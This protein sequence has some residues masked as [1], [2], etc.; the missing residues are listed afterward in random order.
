M[1]QKV[2]PEEGGE[3]LGQGLR[4]VRITWSISLGA[5]GKGLDFSRCLWF[6]SFFF[7]CCES[8]ECGDHCLW[9]CQQTSQLSQVSVGGKL[10]LRSDSSWPLLWV[11]QILHLI[12]KL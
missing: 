7:P 6:F 11:S 12:L 4:G 2:E 8:M 10:E 1:E 5:E 3:G 9:S